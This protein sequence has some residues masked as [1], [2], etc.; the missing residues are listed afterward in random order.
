MKKPKAGEGLPPLAPLPEEQKTVPSGDDPAQ[1]EISRSTIDRIN[2]LCVKRDAAF[3]FEVGK[4]LYEVWGKL[5]VCESWPQWCR[6]HLAF[7]VGT[8]SRYLRIYNAFKDNPGALE[9]RTVTGALRL[10]SEPET[11]GGG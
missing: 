9:G 7:D 1:V 11:G 2:A 5:D 8:A 3:A 10:L 4:L 6:E